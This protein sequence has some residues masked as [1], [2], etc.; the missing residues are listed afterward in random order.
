MGNPLLVVRLSANIAPFRLPFLF[1]P[2]VA[3][4]IAVKTYFD[5]I[6]AK[7]SAESRAKRKADFPGMYVPYALAFDEDLDIACK[8]FDALY[9]GV[10]AL[11]VKEL[12]AVDRA[13]W[14]EAATYL[15]QRR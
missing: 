3:L 5:D 7:D 6:S 10:K 11:D 12:S 15:D 2:D 14:D 9:A 8:F 4:G 13:I 1:D